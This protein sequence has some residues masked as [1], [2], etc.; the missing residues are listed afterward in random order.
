MQYFFDIV[1]P[2]LFNNP[3][4]RNA[5]NSPCFIFLSNSIQ[6][7]LA[8]VLFKK[9]QLA[10]ASKA[11]RAHDVDAIPHNAACILLLFMGAAP[12]RTRPHRQPSRIAST[13]STAISKEFSKE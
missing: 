1:F 5:M 12:G 4:K 10:Q 9:Y 2:W 11:F 8:F 3:A 7:F 6:I 13:V